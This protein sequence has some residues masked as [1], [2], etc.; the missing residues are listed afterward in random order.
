MQESKNQREMQDSCLLLTLSKNEAVESCDP[1]SASEAEE[2]D[3][4]DNAGTSTQLQVNGRNDSKMGDSEK[5]DT[6]HHQKY[7][8]GS[9]LLKN[10]DSDE[11]SGF[12]K[13][14]DT[15]SGIYT[16]LWSDD[17]EDL[18]TEFPIKHL[19]VFSPDTE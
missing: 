1:K 6:H 19:I 14:F 17:M 2:M 7:P 16:V 12:I 3:D 8:N 15:W 18:L 9:L 13:G 4:S 10:V 5:E 11:L